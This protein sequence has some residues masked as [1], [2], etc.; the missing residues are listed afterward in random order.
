MYIHEFNNN[1]IV[2]KAFPLQTH[3]E[4]VYKYNDNNFYNLRKELP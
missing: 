2:S 3:K 4:Q 1:N